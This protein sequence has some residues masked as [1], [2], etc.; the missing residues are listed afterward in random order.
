MPILHTNPMLKKCL[1]GMLATI[2]LAGLLMVLAVLVWG[3]KRGS[4]VSFQDI[5]FWV[6]ALP[7]VVFTMGS[8][9]HFT[10]RG[11]VSYQMSRS[12]SDVTPDRRTGAVLDDLKS[13][14]MSWLTWVLAGLLLWIGSYGMTY[15]S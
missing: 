14:G 9:G 8:M 6:G 12:A 11:D 13:Y 4:G 10:G 3:V 5:L 7:I 15:F 1:K 2:L